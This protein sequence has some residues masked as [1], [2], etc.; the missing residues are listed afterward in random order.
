MYI[1]SLILSSLDSGAT[2]KAHHE[3]PRS[4][5]HS[6]CTAEAEEGHEWQMKSSFAFLPE[7]AGSLW[8]KVTGRA[9]Q[10]CGCTVL[11]VT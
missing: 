4:S 11:D 7:R 6:L 9:E 3:K 5:A 8:V 2:G 10:A 1:P